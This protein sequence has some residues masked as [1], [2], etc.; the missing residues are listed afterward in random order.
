MF[1]VPPITCKLSL[2]GCV[3]CYPAPSASSMC[4]CACVCRLAW[5]TFASSGDTVLDGVPASPSGLYAGYWNA[6]TNNDLRSLVMSSGLKS[7][8][9]SGLRGEAGLGRCMSSC[10]ADP[11]CAG[12]FLE[13]DTDAWPTGL[14]SSCTKII[15]QASNQVRFLTR[16]QRNSLRTYT[17]N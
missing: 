6:I 14:M 11:W 10:D 4:R 8:D 16:M 15:G 12:V 7:T 2:I 3:Q 5:K 9:V 1:R 13:T 17:P